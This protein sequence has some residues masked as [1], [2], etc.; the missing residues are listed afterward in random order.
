M[1]TN[2]LAV[3]TAGTIAL[4]VA[5][6]KVADR[7]YNADKY[8]K[9][10]L[11]ESVE[12]VDNVKSEIESL[13]SELKTTQN[14]IDELNAKE[15][16]SLVEQEELERLKQT[17]DELERE[18]RLKQ[19]ILSEEQKDA[20]KKAKKY[21]TAQKDSLNFESGYEG[22]E[23]HDKID[24]IA[25]VEERID[26]LQQYADGQIK[27]SEESIKAYKN[28]IESALSDFMEE[29]DYL[30]EGQDDGLL[31]RLDAL[32]EKYDI[33][34]NGKASYI[35]EKISGILAK[36]DF[37]S[38]SNS[39]KE[40]G[41][42]GELSIDTLSSRFPDLISYLDKASIS[43]EE[44]YQYIMALSN[45]DAINYDEVKKQLMQSAGIRN[46][47]I[48]GASDNVI[49]NKLTV[50][51]VFNDE[52]LEAYIKIR[53]EYDTS[54]WN[55]DDWIANIQKELDGN[56]LET[57][58]SFSINGYEEAIDDI[59]SSLSTLRSALD[60]FNTGTMDESTVLDLMQQFPELTPY[61]DLA[62]EGFGNLSEGLSVLLAQQ[63]VSLI[64]S[65]QELKDSLNTDAEREQVDLLINSLQSL[66]SYGDSGIEAYATTIGSTWNDTANVI[67]GV[68]NQF[69]N[70]AK[71]QEAVADGLTMSMDAAAE[72]AAMYPEI[73][74]NAEYAGN[75]Q[76]TLNEEVVK[77]ILAGDKSIVD[78]QITKLEADKA[79]LEAKKSYAEAQLEMI[80]QR[81]T[82][83]GK[84]HSTVWI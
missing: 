50:A 35:E 72:L 66:S 2:P 46:G 73:L 18:L 47:V 49:F 6:G 19:S 7:V 14:R 26:R 59:K 65:L 22:V 23:F 76:I 5:I 79:T 42:N 17:N 43:A 64:Q 20:N 63:P 37:Q 78:A 29:D 24:Y 55:V 9:K 71:V 75:G 13:N 84:S 16:I 27:L 81:E 67:E 80:K 68:T 60:A 74:T 70:L 77:S 82:S 58:I 8:T 21:F 45:P 4:G 39:L 12:K 52:S 33:Y 51:D 31:K 38:V 41:K 11:D 32:Y 15:N 57:A 54:S 10:V 28:Y 56:P 44:L 1:I 30:I 3:F 48:N 25:T 83:Q 69:E 36:T 62:A 34:T 40:L 61:I 53:G